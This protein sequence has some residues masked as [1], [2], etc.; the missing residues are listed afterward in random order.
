MSMMTSYTVTYTLVVRLHE[1]VSLN[2]LSKALDVAAVSPRFKSHLFADCS[3]EAGCPLVALVGCHNGL[4]GGFVN[5]WSIRSSV[6]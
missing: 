3:R 6:I 5:K 4:N 2:L 1:F